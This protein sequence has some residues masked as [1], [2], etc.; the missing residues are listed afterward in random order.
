MKKVYEL[1]VYKLA[2]RLSDNIWNDYQIWD[3]KMN[4]ELSSAVIQ[5][6]DS[7]ANDISA[8]YEKMETKDR[9]KK[10]FSSIKKY[11]KTKATLD[12]LMTKNIILNKDAEKYNNIL[13]KL[14]EKL[15]ALLNASKK[16]PVFETQY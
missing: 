11:E 15:F 7:I 12:D 14:D 9:V 10:F 6:A 8:G 3:Q 1:D 2:I 5:N 16:D 4:G 13:G